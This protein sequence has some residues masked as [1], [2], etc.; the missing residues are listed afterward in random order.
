MVVST[1]LHSRAARRSKASR[2]IT[3]QPKPRFRFRFRFRFSLS[4]EQY[5]FQG[6]I[7]QKTP[8]STIGNHAYDPCGPIP[9]G[10]PL[11]THAF[12]RGGSLSQASSYL[13]GSSM[14]SCGVTSRLHAYI[15]GSATKTRLFQDKKN[16]DF[17]G[18]VRGVIH[19]SV[20][21]EE[22]CTLNKTAI[23]WKV[24]PAAKNISRRLFFLYLNSQSGLTGR[25]VER[26]LGQIGAHRNQANYRQNP[27]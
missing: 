14:D 23:I 10:R 4:L 11:P 7:G 12:R 24:Q 18:L 22:C 5:I 27:E 20:L 3:R 1:R 16:P 6:L 17:S 13:I 8:A 21:G 19:V 25:S 15:G 9:E 2:H 26:V